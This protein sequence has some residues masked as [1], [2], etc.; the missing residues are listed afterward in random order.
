MARLIKERHLLLGKIPD[1]VVFIGHKKVET[2]MMRVIDFSP[3]S[4]QE[5]ERIHVRDLPEIPAQEEQ[6]N[7]RWISVYG[8]HDSKSIEELGRLFKIDQLTLKSILNTG[9]RP[10][11]DEFE[12]YLYISLKLVHFNFD[13]DSVDSDQLG[14]VIG[15][16]YLLSFHERPID[17]F[18]PLRKQLKDPSGK[19]RQSGVEYLSYCLLESVADSYLQAVEQIGR[20][21]EDLEA[22]LTTGASTETLKLIVTYKKIIHYLLRTSGPVCDFI[23]DVDPH[24]RS[25]VSPHI[26]PFYV[27]LK[28]QFVQV[29]ETLETYNVLLSEYSE[30][31]ICRKN[32]QLVTT[33]SIFIST[34]IF[35]LL[36]MSYLL[37][38]SS[39]PELYSRARDLT[40]L[41]VVVVFLVVV[42]GLNLTRI[43]N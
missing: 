31:C 17:L 8:L 11:Y 10:K 1:S 36:L 7:I 22:R 19:L 15:H 18:A 28:N 34:F 4:Y 33:I 21:V 16:N 26:D 9:L 3:D 35:A 12:K 38:R 25:V 6:Q 41:G 13:D 2:P 20:K 27:D 29:K 5:L 39:T 23:G 42:I 40:L 24:E 43:R 30:I 37:I 14:I 32:N